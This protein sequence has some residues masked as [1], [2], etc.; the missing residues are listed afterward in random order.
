V[1]YNPIRQFL[2]GTTTFEQAPQASADRIEGVNGIEIPYTPANGNNDRFTSN[3]AGNY[4]RIPGM[5]DR[6][7]I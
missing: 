3:I 7:R 1:R 4:G 5:A 2:N 6:C